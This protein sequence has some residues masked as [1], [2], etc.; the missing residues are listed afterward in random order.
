[1]SNLL[2][3]ELTDA[4]INIFYEVNNGLGYGF[5]ERV[6]Q[7]AL[8]LELKQEGFLVEAQKP[9]KVH[10]KGSVVGDFFADL[11]VENTIILEL[12]ACSALTEEHEIQ[13][14]NY[15]RATD[16]EVG[17]LMNFGRKPT[18]KRIIFTN[19]RKNLKK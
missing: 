19:D 15:L 6:Y 16:I 9:I 11:V 4:I 2:H 13:L 5:L 18:F 17:L 3:K 12:K 14:M 8:Y 10:Y 7:N 1:M